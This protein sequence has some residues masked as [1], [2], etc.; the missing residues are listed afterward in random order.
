MESFRFRSPK[1]KCIRKACEDR[2][3]RPP[4]VGPIARDPRSRNFG[5]DRISIT[6]LADEPELEPMFS[7]SHHCFSIVQEAHRC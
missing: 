2:Q 3:L 4:L 5:T 1:P 6:L 7:I